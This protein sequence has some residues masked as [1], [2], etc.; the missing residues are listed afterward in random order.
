MVFCILYSGNKK[1]VTSPTVFTYT[2]VDLFFSFFLLFSNFLLEA[3]SVVGRAQEEAA[4]AG[5]DGEL[6]GLLRRR[7]G[8]MP[9]GQRKP[10]LK[11]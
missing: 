11:V 5:S 3:P 4:P 6:N 7:Q 10:E 1:R 8:G 9:K 2:K